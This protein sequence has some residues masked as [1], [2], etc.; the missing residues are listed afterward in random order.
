ML[1]IHGGGFIACSPRTH[2]PVTGAL[3]LR[4]FTIFA[5]VTGLGDTPTYE[6]VIPIARNVMES[7][8][9]RRNEVGFCP[10]N[11]QTAAA[12]APANTQAPCGFPP[13]ALVESLTITLPG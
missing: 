1:Y 9:A 13:V 3:A 11:P 5:S 2:R 7:F 10:T 8:M 6:Q 12:G 4:G